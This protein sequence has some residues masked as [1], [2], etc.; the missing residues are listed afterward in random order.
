MAAIIKLAKLMALADGRPDK[1]E[2]QIMST[3]LMR[4]GVPAEQL[5]GLL[6][7]GDE[8]DPTQ[9]LGVIS[10]LD[11]ERKRYVSSYL[12]ALMAIDGDIHDDELKLWQLISTICG[13][14]T[15][16]VGDAISTMASL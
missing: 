14:P 16:S 8:L 10:S 9:A 4:F 12:G 7:A 2:L 11:T 13:L 6:Q 3:E 1:K 5:E 15:M